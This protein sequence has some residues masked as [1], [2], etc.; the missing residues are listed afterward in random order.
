MGKH[1]TDFKHS[2]KYEYFIVFPKHIFHYKNHIK[3][4]LWKRKETARRLQG[5]I[6]NFF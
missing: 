1:T 4:K 2:L 6:M 5:D 3:N